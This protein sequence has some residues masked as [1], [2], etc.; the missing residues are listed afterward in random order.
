MVN[1]EIISLFISLVFGALFFL[2]ISESLADPEFSANSS[3][4]LK[5]LVMGTGL[6]FGKIFWS[7]LTGVKKL[8]LDLSA[9]YHLI[10]F[11]FLGAIV[12]PFGIAVIR[13][14]LAVLPKIFFM[15]IFYIFFVWLAFELKEVKEDPSTGDGEK[16]E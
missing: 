9:V 2:L 11:T 15:M 1:R 14:Q 7:H 6:I 8:Q 4:Y 16:R 12:A 13:N 10:M 5:V 3:D